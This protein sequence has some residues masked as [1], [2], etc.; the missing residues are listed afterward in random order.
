[1]LKKQS[2]TPDAFYS[3]HA[4]PLAM[5]TTVFCQQLG[6][7]SESSQ[8]K[9]AMAALMH[10]MVLSDEHLHDVQKWNERAR[11]SQD[12]SP[13]T[14]KYRNHPIE[15]A[16]LIQT[17]KNLPP[18]IDQI[19]LQHHETPDAKG[20]PRGLNS[21]WISPMSAVFI[22]SEDLI[23]FISDSED[24]RNRINEF[25]NLR[26]K[27]YVEGNFKRVFQALKANLL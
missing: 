9:L 14:L 21:G 6:W 13:E 19:I 8:V 4:G 7:V 15:A 23:Q 5:V 11:N 12:K 22:I 18:D 10:D 25:V 2:N 16:K 1:M 17:I 27:I 20:F 26:E 24:L 3:Q